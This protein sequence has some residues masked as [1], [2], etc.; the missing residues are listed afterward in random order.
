MYVTISNIAKYQYSWHTL[1]WIKYLPVHMGGRKN[2]QFILELP[3][4]E[5]LNAYSNFCVFWREPCQ[6]ATHGVPSWHLTC[7]HAIVS[8][9]PWGHG[10][11]AP[12]K[13]HCQQ[14]MSSLFCGFLPNP[15]IQDPFLWRT[16]QEFVKTD[17][18]PLSLISL[19]YAV[20]PT[21]AS[22]L[23]NV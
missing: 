6:H 13:R 16:S 4:R 14:W 2:T 5:H 22:E 10:S 11:V 8:R 12:D 21:V 23:A 3:I 20:C 7:I 18:Y 15:F 19:R 1:T 9:S 17:L